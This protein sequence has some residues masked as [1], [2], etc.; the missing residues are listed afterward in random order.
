MDRSTDCFLIES[1]HKKIFSSDFL[2]RSYGSSD[3]VYCFLRSSRK[4]CK[5][6]KTKT[7]AKNHC[8]RFFYNLRW[9]ISGFAAYFTAVSF[10]I[11]PFLY[12]SNRL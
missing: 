9:S 7:K 5:L 12:K 6:K 11:R 3:Y 8:L 2:R 10:V 4:S 1:G